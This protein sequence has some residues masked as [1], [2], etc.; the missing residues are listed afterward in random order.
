[1]QSLNNPAAACGSEHGS[2][3]I[4]FLASKPAPA[5]LQAL[6]RKAERR[7]HNKAVLARELGVTYGYLNQLVTGLRQVENVSAH[8]VRSC[9]KYLEI[10]AVA[11][12]LLAG[13]ISL[14]DFAVPEAARSPVQQLVEG[15]Q[16]IADDP[17][18]GYLVP[19]EVWDA[20]DSVKALLI[21]LYEDATQQELFPP[22]RLPAMLQS[23]Q[24]AAL[25]LA[26]REAQEQADALIA[27]SRG[28][29]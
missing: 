15:L 17:V 12:M 5:L 29:H 25:V 9:A 4:P 13:K 11:V 2:L 27:V 10:P 14:L 22:K 1:M 24:D 23:L 18:V 20:P 7:G 3:T 16:R 28:V 8:F 19:S 6:Y 26:E 21:A